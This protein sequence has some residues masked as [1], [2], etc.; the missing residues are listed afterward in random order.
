LEA[1]CGPFATSVAQGNE[2]YKNIGAALVI[3]AQRVEI[4]ASEDG[5]VIATCFG[6]SIISEQCVELTFALGQKLF[7]VSLAVQG[8]LSTRSSHLAEL[9]SAILRQMIFNKTRERWPEILP[10]LF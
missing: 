10:S 7:L 8:L 4:P 3:D 1:A 6:L 9:L 2:R 5:H